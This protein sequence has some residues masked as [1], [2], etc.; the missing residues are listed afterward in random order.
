MKKS[1]I[2]WIVGGGILA[3]ILYQKYNAPVSTGDQ[4]QSLNAT[5]TASDVSQAALASQQVAAALAGMV[6]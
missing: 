5:Q 4:G 1:T 2:W 3:Y 6:Q